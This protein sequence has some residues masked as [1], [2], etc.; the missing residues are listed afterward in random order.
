[1]PDKTEELIIKRIYY[2]DINGELVP[3]HESMLAYLLDEEFI[4]S[5]NDYGS[6]TTN[7]YININDYF[8]PAADAE[9]LPHRDIP[10][11]FEMYR[12]DGFEGICQYV[13]DV[14]GIPNQHWK[15]KYEI[16]KQKA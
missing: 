7:L 10:K 11:L 4:F 5:G 12:K 6:G 14:R 15:E 16:S 9:R 8:A 1:M 13:A 3:D 2:Y